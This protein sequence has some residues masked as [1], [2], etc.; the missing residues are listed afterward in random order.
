[1]WYPPSKT[2]TSSHNHSDTEVFLHDSPIVTL[3][4]SELLSCVAIFKKLL[5]WFVLVDWESSLLGMLITS[6]V[7]CANGVFIGLKCILFFTKIWST[8]FLIKYDLG[9]P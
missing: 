7:F 1:M 6:S 8:M 5:V 2:S 9:L 3:G 4:T